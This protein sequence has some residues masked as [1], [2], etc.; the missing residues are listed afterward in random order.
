MRWEVQHPQEDQGKEK[1]Q[2][3]SQPQE[4]KQLL[5]CSKHPNGKA[6]KTTEVHFCFCDGITQYM[7]L[8]GCCQAR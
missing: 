1:E 7:V 8:L 4:E 5:S 6:G 2:Q 3:T